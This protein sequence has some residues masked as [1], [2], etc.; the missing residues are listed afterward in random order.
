MAKNTSS[1]AF[2]KIDVDEYNEDNYKE[3]EVQS[4]VT[5][6]DENEIIQ[7]LSHGK[8]VDALKTCLRSAPLGS[9]NQKVKVRLSSRVK[10]LI[11]I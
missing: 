2:R 10:D 11:R 4:S 1:S 9:R 6:P 8:N 5:G 3:E 7:L